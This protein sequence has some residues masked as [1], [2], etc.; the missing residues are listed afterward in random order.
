[1]RPPKT[2]I[3]G[4]LALVETDGIES[5]VKIVVADPWPDGGAVAAVEIGDGCGSAV[6]AVNVC[7]SVADS[8]VNCVSPS[9]VAAAPL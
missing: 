6:A 3:T 8:S 7:A 9:E 2:G 4:V 1:M 5:E